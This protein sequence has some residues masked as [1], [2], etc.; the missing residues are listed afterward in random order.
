[1]VYIYVGGFH[2]VATKAEASP[3]KRPQAYWRD[4]EVVTAEL[5]RYLEDEGCSTERGWMP[6]ARE[7]VEAGRGDIRYALSVSLM[8][9]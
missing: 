5:K 7:L 9:H 6:T 4:L 3:Y 1:M 8:S 2:I